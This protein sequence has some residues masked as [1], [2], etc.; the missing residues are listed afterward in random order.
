M[1]TQSWTLVCLLSC[2]LSLLLLSLSLSLSFSLWGPFPSKWNYHLHS[3]SDQ[4]L[5]IFPFFQIP[6]AI[7]LHHGISSYHSR[8]LP[9][10]THLDIPHWSRRTFLSESATSLPNTHWCLAADF[11]TNSQIPNRVRK[12]PIQAF[13]PSCSPG[14]CPALPGVQGHLC[15]ANTQ[16]SGLSRNFTFQNLSDHLSSPF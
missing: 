4:K 8:S 11:E 1:I 15:L 6:H 7:T 16:N 9:I 3:G 13:F 14:C 2:L 5:K 12:I 10:Y